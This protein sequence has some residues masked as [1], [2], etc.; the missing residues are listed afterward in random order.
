MRRGKPWDAEKPKKQWGHETS[1][2]WRFKE[3]TSLAAAESISSRQRCW[4]ALQI[5]SWSQSGSR[6]PEEVTNGV[7]RPETLPMTAM[8]SKA[9]K[10]PIKP[11]KAQQRPAKQSKALCLRR[12]ILESICDDMSRKTF[13]MTRPSEAQHSPAKHSNSSKAQEKPQ[14]SKKQPK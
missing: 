14:Q 5:C 11:S 4:P 3:S 12:H 1:P 2:Y 10:S 6:S 7:R 9:H 13:V 8:A